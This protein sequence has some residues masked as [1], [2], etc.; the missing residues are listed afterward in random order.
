MVSVGIESVSPQGLIESDAARKNAGKGGA[1][2]GLE[3]ILNQ[4]RV[5][6]EH[7]LYILAWFV[8][9]WDSDRQ[10][11]YRS[12]L[13]FADRAGVSPGRAERRTQQSRS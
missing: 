1:A 13:E 8:I 5:L 7:G 6:K 11:Q 12:T 10:E 3:T 9:G 4:I 2:P